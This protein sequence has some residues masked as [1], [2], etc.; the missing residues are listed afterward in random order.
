MELASITRDRREVP[1]R[2]LGVALLDP[3]LKV[4]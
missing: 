4:S 3:D 2:T 1:G